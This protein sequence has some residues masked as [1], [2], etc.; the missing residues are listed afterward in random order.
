M[1]FF[2][3]LPCRLIQELR[4]VHALAESSHEVRVTKDARSRF[5]KLEELAGPLF[6]EEPGEVV[7]I[8]DSISFCHEQP[9]SVIAGIERQLIFPHRIIGFCRDQWREERPTEFLFQGQVSPHRLVQLSD[10]V[11][12][13]WSD[14]ELVFKE[15]DLLARLTTALRSS[16]GLHTTREFRTGGLLIV[17]SNRGR[18]FPLKAWDETY[19]RRMAQAQFVLCPGG[20]FTWSYRFVEAMFCGAIPVVDGDCSLFEGFQFF[21]WEDRADSLQWDARIA[22]ENFH[23]AVERFSVPR[24]ELDGALARIQQE[25]S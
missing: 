19:F 18:K 15:E 7:D 12:E 24:E 16:I 6:A 8:S 4:L 2:V 9:K 21:R 25:N 1:S 22:E 5:R 11:R 14:K 17:E 10:W 3:S 13:N 20:S 23:R